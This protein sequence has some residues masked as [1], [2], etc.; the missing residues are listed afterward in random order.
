MQLRVTRV[1]KT[2]PLP[3]YETAGAVA[4]DVTAR[5]E[6]VIAPKSLGFVPSNL[7]VCVPAGYALMLASRSSTPKK[8]GLLIPHG[9]GI[10]DQDFCGPNDEM[11]VQVYNFTDAPVTVPRGERIAQALLMPVE[12]CDLREMEPVTMKSR[13]GFG[14]TG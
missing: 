9:I 12:K 14:S 1:D 3:K 5:E 10:V 6:T 8:K 2:L 13:G 11:R 4:F 7:I